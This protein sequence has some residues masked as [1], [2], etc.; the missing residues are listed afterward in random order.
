[1]GRTI[2]YWQRGDGWLAVWWE[3]NR[4]APYDCKWGKTKAEALARIA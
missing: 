1:M 3:P 2:L 4:S